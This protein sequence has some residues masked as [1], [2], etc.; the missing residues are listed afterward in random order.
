MASRGNVARAPEDQIRD[1]HERIAEAWRVILVQAVDFANRLLKPV[2]NFWTTYRR[3]MQGDCCAGELPAAAKWVADNPPFPSRA[4]AQWIRMMYRDDALVRSRVRPRERRVD[5]ARID[6]HLLVMTAA[7]DHIAP[8]ADT[9]HHRSDPERQ[10][11]DGHAKACSPCPRDA[12]E[13][14]R[15]G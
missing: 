10:R 2:S 4:W 13:G 15:D 14:G 6:Q 5:L 12:T 7:G 8:R 9:M 1:L 3:L 11:R